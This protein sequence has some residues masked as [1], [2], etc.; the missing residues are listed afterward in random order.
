MKRRIV[1]AGGGS[2]GWIAAI[3]FQHH[4]TGTDAEI[5]LVESDNV[6]VI[7]VGEGSTP[8]LRQL[9]STLGIAEDDWMPHCHATYKNGIRFEGWHS[10][11]APGYFH[12]FPSAPDRHTA[13]AFLQACERRRQ[14]SP[15]ACLP[16]DYF[17]ANWLSAHHKSPLQH[18]G[19]VTVSLNYAYHFDAAGLA[20]FLEKHTKK[21]GLKHVKGTVNAV[22]RHHNGDIDALLLDDGQRIPGDFFIDCTGFRSL[23]LQQTLK[24]GFLSY[25][26]SLFNDAA[27]ACF[28]ARHENPVPATR[29]VA[30]AN[31]WRWEIPLT[32]RTGNGYVYSS[33]FENK[34]NAAARL[35]E[36]LGEHGNAD[37]L[38][39]IPMKVGRTASSWAKNCLAVGLS[40]GFIE[41]L[42]AT[43]LHLVQET[44]EQ[45]LSAWAAGGYTPLYRDEFNSRIAGRFDGIRDSIVAH[46]VLSKRPGKYWDAFRAEAKRSDTLS[47]LLQCWNE[48]GNL[49]QFIQDNQIGHYYS[50]VSWYCL[51]S[52]YDVFPAVTN[53]LQT[54]ASL[55]AV[56]P[57]LEKWGATFLSHGK[58]LQRMGTNDS[59]PC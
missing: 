47:A 49:I 9:F 31:G 42:E 54:D 17:L 44:T 25:A 39:H 27:V 21:Q 13:N 22:T 58:A 30:M 37:D 36:A 4:F 16:D 15:I 23:L 2:A 29:S 10:D 53:D 28:S 11:H 33:Q 55:S 20:R 46:Y 1:I 45:F 14:R 26:D 19:S 24:V 12:P 59:I 38:R 48:G 52:G 32:H 8:H 56:T 40:Q 50:A 57:L 51:L 34:H 3:L 41:P 5:T 43:A 18:K 35:T 7:G 6:P